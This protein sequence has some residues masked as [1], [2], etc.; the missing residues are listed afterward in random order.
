MKIRTKPIAALGCGAL[1][2]ALLPCQTAQALLDESGTS[3][4]ADTTVTVTASEPITVSWSVV[5]TAPSDYVYSYMVN[6][7][8]GDVL[9]N[10][11]G[12]PTTTPEIVDSL[13]VGFDTTVAG[14]VTSTPT[15]LSGV[16]ADG[17][18]WFLY[19]V[20]GPDTS[21]V[22]LSF[23][24][25]LPPSPGNASAEPAP[26]ASYPGGDAVPVPGTGN[27]SVPDSTDTMTLL[28]GVLLL[29]PFGAAM[30]KKTS[31]VY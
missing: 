10:E 3:T 4:L 13:S 18:N 20:V 16:A 5:E 12:L 14:A 8:A 2:L 9:L 29:L 24:S 19:P 25:D 31:S 15:G 1:L 6:N 26:W 27:F 22:W 30:R 11:D 21:S 23:D 28:A 7:P 17:V